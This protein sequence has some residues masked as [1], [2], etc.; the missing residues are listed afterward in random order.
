MFN[1][2]ERPL[3]LVAERLLS[4]RLSL[5][6]PIVSTDE[7]P[8]GPARAGI[9]VHS[10]SGRT[11]FT[12]AVRSLP[13]GVSVLYELDS[14]DISQP[15]D[16]ALA[17]D[18]SLSFGES[19]GF[20]FDDDM[21]VDREPGTLRQAV[22]RLREIVSSPGPDVAGISA[23]DLDECGDDAEILLEEALEQGVVEA[24]AA[25]PLAAEDRCP[26]E[27]ARAALETLEPLPAPG[28]SPS[29]T[30]FR[31]GPSHPDPSRPAS[32]PGPHAVST[33]RSP[34]PETPGGG[35]R[36]GR[37]QPVRMRAPGVAPPV[38]PL[39]RLLAAF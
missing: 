3:L 14:E 5:N 7:L 8:A 33:P 18:A 34:T 17:L 12:V 2:R 16:M 21:I 4:L 15:D 29:L 10:E 9:A 20:L 23:S 31:T 19:M 13:L 6:T 28:I 22:A 25:P 11:R 36:L 32:E 26:T 37:V 30:K 35:A 38:P 27:T 24:P 1:P 39:L